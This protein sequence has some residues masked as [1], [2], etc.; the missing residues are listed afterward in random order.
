MWP[1]IIDYLTLESGHSML[2]NHSKFL[3]KEKKMNKR[4]RI[5]LIGLIA[6]LIFITF[7]V[8]LST[9]K[10]QESIPQNQEDKQILEVISQ[11][12]DL[13]AKAGRTFDF[14]AFDTVFINDPRGGNLDTSTV[15]F[16][17]SITKENKKSFYGYLDYKIAY[18]SWWRDGALKYERL[19][20][21]AEST[22]RGLT[23]EESKSLVDEK[24]RMAMPRLQGNY[25]PTKL[26]FLSLNL[27]SDIAVVVFDDG[28]RTN[29]MTMVKFNDKWYIAGN[30]ILAIHI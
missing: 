20:S 3:T 7:G 18:Y 21:N 24:G 14:S 8:N 26:T 5:L 16:I 22:K 6:I 13:E 10:S 23:T 12:Y 29:Q 9:G 2:N 19:T 25:V 15:D 27:K 11:S 28:P 4:K 30:I 17:T 1:G